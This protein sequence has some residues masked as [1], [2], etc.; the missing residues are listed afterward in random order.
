MQHSDIYHILIY[1]KCNTHIY[2]MH[3]SFLYTT[4]KRIWKKMCLFVMEISQSFLFVFETFSGFI[5]MLHLWG[6]VC[7]PMNSISSY[8]HTHKHLPLTSQSPD[9]TRIQW[10]VSGAARCRWQKEQ[11]YTGV[12]LPLPSEPELRWSSERWRLSEQ[13]QGCQSPQSHT[14]RERQPQHGVRY[15]FKETAHMNYTEFQPE[16][17]GVL[18]WLYRV[19]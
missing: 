14:L 7:L 1:I 10:S 15:S 17:Q 12:L 11:V 5:W 8:I 9:V 19:K 6:C 2:K 16:K 13:Q 18:G 4:I 3:H